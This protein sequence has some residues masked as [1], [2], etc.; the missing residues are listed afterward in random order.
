MER[1]S[2][3]SPPTTNPNLILYPSPIGEISKSHISG[4]CGQ[5]FVHFWSCLQNWWNLIIP[6]FSGIGGGGG[7]DCVLTLHVFRIFMPSRLLC[8][9][10]QLFLLTLCVKSTNL[11]YFSVEQIRTSI[12]S[13]KN[14]K[15]DQFCNKPNFRFSHMPGIREV[16]TF[17][18]ERSNHTKFTRHK[19]TCSLY[20]SICQDLVYFSLLELHN[21]LPHPL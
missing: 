20:F 4:W 10:H 14:A 13:I 6:Y 1:G 5:G 8:S 2:N 12:I 11:F 15:M 17:L 7:G 18:A 9:K 16:L 19:F 21:L 3:W